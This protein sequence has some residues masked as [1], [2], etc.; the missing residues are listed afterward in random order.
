MPYIEYIPRR[1]SR[2]SQQL[3]GIANNIIGEFTAEG[4]TLTV[5]QL[6][7]QFVARDIIKNN[8]KEYK[9]LVSLINDARLAG[10]IDWNAIEDRTRNL[11][12][13]PTYDT[14]KDF[15][16]QIPDWFH[17]DFWKDQDTIIEVWVEKEALIGVVE[18]ASFRYRCAF[19]ACRGYVSQSEAWAAGQR[20]LNYQ[21]N[22]KR[23]IVLHL[24][25]HDPKSVKANFYP[26]RP[27][28]P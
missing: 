19:F 2:K 10:H 12:S 22:K 6:Y 8:M 26:S 3:I 4:Y 21:A 14:E 18:R 28:H 13:V 23:V 17:Y 27:N 11:T 16:E 25:D 24:G 9:N 7:Y 1:F 15:L 20:Y 5:R